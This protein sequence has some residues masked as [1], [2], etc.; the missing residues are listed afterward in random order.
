MAWLKLEKTGVMGGYF[1]PLL[2]D[3]GKGFSWGLVPFMIIW[4]IFGVV[5]LVSL[6]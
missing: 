1:L 2:P 4:A 6:L 3:G 5:L